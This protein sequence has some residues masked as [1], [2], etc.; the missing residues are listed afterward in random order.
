MKKPPSLRPSITRMQQRLAAAR[1]LPAEQQ[2]TFYYC[3]GKDLSDFC[4]EL[5]AGNQSAINLA[6]DVLATEQWLQEQDSTDYAHSIRTALQT[7]GLAKLLTPAQQKIHLAI[8]SRHLQRLLLRA[9]HSEPGT[10]RE[11]ALR[12]IPARQE[13]MQQLFGHIPSL[14][15]ERDAWP[16]VPAPAAL[17]HRAARQQLISTE[18]AEQL[19][20][21]SYTYL[22]ELIHAPESLLPTHHLQQTAPAP[23]EA[24][25]YLFSESQNGTADWRIAPWKEIEPHIGFAIATD[26][27]F[28][29]LNDDWGSCHGNTH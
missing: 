21:S 22:M 28:Y 20:R 25:C 12:S 5:A 23:A 4:A 8:E 27:T 19:A 6:L 9:Y 1:A 3:D 29:R 11:D 7:A 14:R 18:Q 17:L 24:L 16:T 26:A 2:A 15:I 13:L 10:D